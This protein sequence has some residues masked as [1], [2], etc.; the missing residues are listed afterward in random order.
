MSATDELRRM[1][2]ERGIK[3]RSGLKGVTFVGDW[4]FVEYV[5]GELA[6]TCEPVLTSEQ[7][8]AA[9]LGNAFT[10]EECE[11]SFVH[12]YSL[13]ALP[14]GSDPQWDE[15]VQTVD[16]HMAELGWVR[17]RTCIRE[18]HGVKMDGSPKLRCSLCGY[19]IGDKRWGYCPN[20]GARV[21]EE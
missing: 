2:D 6:A 8:I 12:G 3:W 15:N 9:T 14:V 7:A 4:C 19:G 11:A 5:N 13:G 10:R 1:L 21:V 20:C 18:K 16:E 17:E